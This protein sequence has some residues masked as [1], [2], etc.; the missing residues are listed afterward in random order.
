MSSLTTKCSLFLVLCQS[1]QNLI[2]NYTFLHLFISMPQYLLLHLVQVTSFWLLSKHCLI[3]KPAFYLSSYQQTC[4]L[5]WSSVLYAPT[6]CHSHSGSPLVH[7][8]HTFFGQDFNVYDNLCIFISRRKIKDSNLHI[9]RNHIT[10]G[11]LYE[12]HAKQ[13]I[14]FSH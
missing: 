2:N 14:S 9:C 7:K 4:F 13:N 11:C 1:K 10:N 6:K 3:K 8:C 5:S 12:K